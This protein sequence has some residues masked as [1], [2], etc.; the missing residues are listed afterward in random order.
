MDAFTG[1]LRECVQVRFGEEAYREGVPGVGEEFMRDK[2]D[3]I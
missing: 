3:S 1:K 2:G